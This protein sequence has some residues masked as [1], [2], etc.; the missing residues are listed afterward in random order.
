MRIAVA[1]PDRE[2]PPSRA[3]CFQI[4]SL[5]RASGRWVNRVSSKALK[6]SLAIALVEATPGELFDGNIGKLGRVVHD[7]PF[8]GNGV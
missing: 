8:D 3:L 7:L 4:G 2:S 6:M 1:S 5:P